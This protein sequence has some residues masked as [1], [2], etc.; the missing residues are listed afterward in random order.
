M[1]GELRVESSFRERFRLI[2]MA[3][4]ADGDRSIVPIEEVL[5]YGA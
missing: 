1:A 5:V 3:A 2:T 4:I